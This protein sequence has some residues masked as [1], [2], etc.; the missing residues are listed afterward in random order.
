M[1]DVLTPVVLPRN[2]WILKGP[3]II[4]GLRSSSGRPNGMGRADRIELR[5]CTASAGS[6]FVTTLRKD[7]TET[8][9]GQLQF[10]VRELLGTLV[11]EG[12]RYRVNHCALCRRPEDD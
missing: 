10:R 7:E 2:S 11:F 8:K 4:I 1:G 9:R 5:A 6:T 12:M 3:G